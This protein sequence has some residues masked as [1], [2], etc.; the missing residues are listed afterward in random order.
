MELA[1]ILSEE[2][3]IV[4]SGLKTKTEVLRQLAERAARVTGGDAG[5]IYDAL[6]DREA[7]GSTGLGN[8]IAIPHG[9]LANLS[10]VTAVFA[11]LD[12]PI[13]FEA[14]DDQPVDLM[15]MLLAPVGAGADHL[16]ALA[17]VARLLRN[18][19]TVEALRGAGNSGE[20]YAIL[21]QPVPATKA[22]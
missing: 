8:G 20:I 19:R 13:D 6:S 22:A 16:K 10:S 15:M 2:S 17:R 14:V 7:L 4:C 5:H 11:R 1:D 9:K 12:T 18:E 21:T 3:V